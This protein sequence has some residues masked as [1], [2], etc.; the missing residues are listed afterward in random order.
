MYNI[1]IIIEKLN[2]GLNNNFKIFKK[3]QKKQTARSLQKYILIDENNKKYLLEI[4]TNST[5]I[6]YFN[7]TVKFQKEFSQLK[8]NFKL[9]MPIYIQTGNK[10][11]YSLYDYFENIIFLKDDRP[12]ELLKDFYKENSIEVELNDENIEKI[13]SNFLSTWP[14]NYHSMIKRQ[15]EFRIYMRELKKLKTIF[16]TF[17]HGDFSTNNI[18][19]SSNE[20]YLLDFEFSRDFQPIGFDTIYYEFYLKNTFI[21]SKYYIKINY[22]KVFLDYLV[23]YIVDN[24]V[25]NIS[26]I[27]KFVL[28]IKFLYLYKK[29]LINVF[30][31][32]I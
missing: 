13:V 9:N 27:N 20:I 29:E 16:V 26:K 23:N 25:R 7:R 21:N 5:E 14:N 24:N 28:Y 19:K 22:I 10:L 17:E 6:F 12:I 11:S 32:R 15:K 2:Q 3:L 18:I 4:A 31:Q 30:K 8:H 1:D